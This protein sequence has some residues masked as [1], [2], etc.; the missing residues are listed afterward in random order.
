MLRPVGRRSGERRG[1]INVLET[2]QVETPS[3]LFDD[4]NYFL[5]ASNPTATSDTRDIEDEALAL[6][7]HPAIV[8]ARAQAT[9]RFKVL[10]SAAPDEALEGIEEKMEEWTFHYTALAC[11]ADPNYPR[12]LGHGYGPP[13]EWFGRKVPGCRGL[14]TGENVDNHYSFI[15]VDGNARF[16]VYGKVSGHTP[17]GDCPFWV[18]S[19][20][21]MS[22]NVVG[23]DFREM[24]IADD[25]TFVVTLDPEPADGRPNHLQTTPD[26]KFLFIRDGRKNWDQIPNAYRVKRLDPPTR[27]PMTRE[28]KAQLAHR[29]V[30]DD[31]PSNWFFAA[32]VGF[33]AP[34]T[35]EGPVVSDQVGG[36]PIQKLGRARIRIEDD[37]A[38]VLTMSSAGSEYWIAVNYDWWLMSGDFWSRTSSLNNTQAVA[39]PDGTHTLVFSIKD[40]GVHNWMDTLGLHDFLFLQRWQLLPLG[41]DGPG[42]ELWGKGEV[43]KLADLPTVLP[44]GT[45]PV[46]PEEREQQ[47]ANRLAS[48]NR[49]H[50]V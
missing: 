37:E 33:L 34:N 35:F 44:A 12:V 45:N 30:I 8:N 39:N 11:N 1:G 20:L 4:D 21:S 13:H 48:F 40:P 27:P 43:V 42:G 26:S 24:Q 23:L 7:D 9:W 25:G 10:G 36:M 3:A 32:M 47:L 50:D 46:T 17:I 14:A 49:R 2:P 22:R 16:E 29:F 6:L 5:S 28:E 41:P 15:P 18:V 31:V 19:N 38:F